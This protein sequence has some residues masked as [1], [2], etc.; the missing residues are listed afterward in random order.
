MTLDLLLTTERKQ[1]LWDKF[2]EIDR[3]TWEGALNGM[4]E[5]ELMKYF[6]EQ[7]ECLEELCAMDEAEQEY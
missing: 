1:M 4:K 7:N 3:I 6:K 5:S 2:H